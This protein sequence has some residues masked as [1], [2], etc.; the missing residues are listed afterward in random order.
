MQLG[1]YG[2]QDRGCPQSNFGSWS[3]G[4]SQ[5]YPLTVE[6]NVDL[7]LLHWCC[8]LQWDSERDLADT[9]LLCLT[10]S[11][12]QL[13]MPRTSTSL[14]FLSWFGGL[15]RHN[16]ERVAQEFRVL[17]MAVHLH[18]PLHCTLRIA[19]NCWDI[20]V[21]VGT[22][23]FWRIVGWGWQSRIHGG[24]MKHF[25]HWM[26]ILVMVRVSMLHFDFRILSASPKFIPF[27][28]F[29]FLCNQCAFFITAFVCLSIFFVCRCWGFR[30]CVRDALNLGFVPKRLGNTQK[31]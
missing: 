12:N 25:G 27:I 24:I 29:I 11:P 2:W 13:A 1:C 21:I 5:V 4:G 31:V 10:P 9:G 6:Y 26:Q 17:A 22:L 14:G 3:L 8:L 20:V 30:S 23:G 18:S 7:I 16:L 19:Y 28:F 15:W